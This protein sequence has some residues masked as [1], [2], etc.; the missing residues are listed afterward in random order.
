MRKV[1]GGPVEAISKPDQKIVYALLPLY[2]GY[3]CQLISRMHPAHRARCKGPAIWMVQS[4][5]NVLHL[6]TVESGALEQ[7]TDLIR[8]GQTA[9]RPDGIASLRPDMLF[10]SGR[11]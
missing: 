4:E 10:E 6:N 11:L 2:F 1:Y 7:R 3:L 8:I 9:Y 5:A